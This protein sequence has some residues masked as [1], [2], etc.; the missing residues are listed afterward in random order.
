MSQVEVFTPIDHKYPEFKKI[1]EPLEL[2]DHDKNLNSICHQFDWSYVANAN[3]A[4][5][6]YFG[7][8]TPKRLY[9][10]ELAGYMMPSEEVIYVIMPCRL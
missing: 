10:F 8:T 1:I 4:L 6:T 3:A 2:N 7:N 9:S 5:C